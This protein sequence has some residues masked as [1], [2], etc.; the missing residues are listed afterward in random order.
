MLALLLGLHQTPLDLHPLLQRAYVHFKSQFHKDLAADGVNA[1]VLASFY[2]PHCHNRNTTIQ[3]ASQ[4]AELGSVYTLKCVNRADLNR[5]LVRSE[6]AELFLPEIELTIPPNGRGQLT[7]VEG[8]ISAVVEDLAG[9]QPLRKQHAVEVY[10]KIEGLLNKLRGIIAPSSSDAAPEDQLL[11]M[12]F[13][14]RMD[15]PTGNSFA[16]PLGS[17]N[18]PKWSKRDYSR[19]RQQEVQLGLREESD[20]TADYKVDNPDE[21]LSFP[22]QCSSCNATLETFMKKV[23]IPHFKVGL[24]SH[25]LPLHTGADDVCSVYRRSC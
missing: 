14:L 3:S 6:F 11:A 8:I 9:E 24:V 19:S 23:D 16:E 2:C 10:D 5:Q 1:V 21:V 25:S 7:T 12:P 18:D 17:L 13:T 22:G 20:L 15:D 4:I